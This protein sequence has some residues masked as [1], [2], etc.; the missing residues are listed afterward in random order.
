MSQRIALRELSQ[1][2][3]EVLAHL[4]AS[5]KTAASL[6]KRARMVG[7]YYEG[8][9]CLRIARQL[10]VDDETVRFWIHRFS[11]FD[12]TLVEESAVVGFLWQKL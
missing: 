10:E 6:V 9:S 11:Q 4:R 2:E 3:Q 1:Q 7:K 12:R 5:R 8:E